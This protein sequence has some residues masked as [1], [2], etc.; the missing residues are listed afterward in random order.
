MISVSGEYISYFIWFLSPINPNM[1]W[2]VYE[3]F[4]AAAVPVVAQHAT[5]YPK[6]NSNIKLIVLN[7]YDLPHPGPPSILIS[8]YSLVLI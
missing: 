8:I 4:C 1:L 5:F 7:K 6:P 2:A 3:L